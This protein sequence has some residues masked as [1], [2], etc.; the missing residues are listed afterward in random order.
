MTLKRNLPHNTVKNI[1]YPAPNFYKSE[2][3]LKYV[4]ITKDRRKKINI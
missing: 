4:S 2:G 3:P 1:N